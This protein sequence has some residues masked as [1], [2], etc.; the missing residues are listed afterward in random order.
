MAYEIPG[1]KFGVLPAGA[2][3]SAKQFTAVTV[4]AVSGV[5]SIVSAGAGASAH[6]I[7]QNK[8]ISGEAA[9]IME[10]GVSKA[11]LGG[12]V[13]VDD[14]LSGDANGKLI[15]A[16]TGAY[17]YA[18]ALEAGVSGDVVAVKLLRDGVKA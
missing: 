5:P 13:A 9:E 16:I 15:V 12:T 4:A 17:I 11:L 14:Q 10:S 7:L 6:G 18:R 2:D 3:L 8:P 1:R